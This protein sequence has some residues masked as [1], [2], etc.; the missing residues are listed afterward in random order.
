MGRGRLS[1]TVAAGAC[2]A[3]VA[4]A[5]PA[6][7]ATHKHR[8][9]PIRLSGV[10]VSQ[11]K[12]LKSGRI[13]V[14]V[15]RRRGISR[16][17]VFASVRGYGKR[18]VPIVAT[19]IRE[20]KVRR[21]HPRKV[22]LRLNRAGRNAL[23]GC[24]K[25]K[26]VI[27][28][29]PILSAAGKPGRRTRRA[30]PLRRDRCGK[31]GSGARGGGS[32]GGSGG[33]GGGGAGRARPVDFTPQNADRCDWIDE[34]DCMFPWPNDFFTTGDATTDT[35]RRLNLNL[36]SMPKNVEGK[37][38]DP[39][40]Y[41]RNDGFSP[42]SLIT[43]KVRGLETRGVFQRSGIVPID[44]MGQAFRADQPVVVID[45]KTAARHLI[46]AELDAN[47]KN[48]ADVTLIIRPGRNLL[49]GRRY[50][51]ALRRLKDAV[52]RTIQPS[53]GFRVYRDGNPTKSTAVEDR[54]AHFE[55]I[56]DTLAQAGIDRDDLYRAWDF[57][58]ASERN[59]SERMLSIRDAAFKDL[60]D[61]NLADLKP[62][63][64]VPQWTAHKVAQ[65]D[66]DIS[67]TVEGEYT[68]PCY[69]NAPG[70]PS[71]S[72]FLFEPGKTT[73]T[74]LPGNTTT[75]RFTCLVPKVAVANGGARI[76]LYGH[77]L[78]GSR[79][80]VM[81]HQARQMTQ[82]H[83]FVYCATDWIGMSCADLPDVPPSA[84]DV[85]TLFNNIAAGILPNPP[86]CDYQTVLSIEHDLSNFPKLA[87]RVQQ[88]ILNFL[89]LQRLM[90]NPKGFNS[91]P[92]FRTAAGKPMLDT[93]RAYYDG[94]S[95][96]GIIGGSLASVMV[97]GDR[98]VLGVPGMNYSTLLQR[99]TDF[100]TGKAPDPSNPDLPEYS[101]G[102]YTSYP[103]QLQ[104][105]LILSLMQILWDRAEADGYAHHMTD[106]P[107]PNTPPHQVMLH[108]GIGDHQV[109]QVAAETEAR[110]I[111]A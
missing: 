56:F 84:D 72:E 55:G 47:P 54:R 79:G 74:R 1:A 28:A 73:P 3:M 49:E 33:S 44:D 96:G 24:S 91:S 39:A 66:A 88:G 69:L 100:G 101:Y 81:Q 45:T 64:E 86:N 8:K 71:G 34:A 18:A 80:E 93:T 37:P 98:A 38:I 29:A 42:G 103:N 65:N 108:G 4:G 95:Q 11:S 17:R 90:A 67:Y 82:E 57:T 61:T 110:T 21:R 63:G 43:T 106:D 107:Y 99:S 60:G 53:T 32:S 19:R 104:R 22:R 68:V 48:P 2:L 78:L 105:P 26:I 30:R 75:A 97:D 58:V 77:G 5:M 35:K 46:W 59:L 20:L 85:A 10:S 27:T 87:D 31:G 62:D 16:V 83:D 52:G 76:S 70:C 6:G 23:A 14:R 15:S 89:Y 41:N 9:A 102:L 7:A 94:N 13:A 12:I 25:R 51:V 109:A 50:I 36:L 92:L 40:P 111:G